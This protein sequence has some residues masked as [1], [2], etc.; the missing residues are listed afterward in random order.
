MNKKIMHRLPFFGVALGMVILLSSCEIIDL[1][2]RSIERNYGDVS[3]IYAVVIPPYAIGANESSRAEVDAFFFSNSVRRSLAEG[4]KEYNSVTSGPKVRAAA[5]K[6][7][8]GDARFYSN[9]APQNKNIRIACRNE[10]EKYRRLYPNAGISC[11][12][13]GIYPYK[14][15][16]N[17]HRMQLYFYDYAKDTYVYTTGAVY[18][19]EGRQQ[20]ADL[21]RLMKNL[22]TK[23]YQ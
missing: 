15:E 6:A 8:K 1:L 7:D 11:L 22:L 5:H 13:F 2:S 10:L 3:H 23:V 14:S 16:A 4:I 12:I 20:A 18:K 9:I 21:Q 17:A 19:E